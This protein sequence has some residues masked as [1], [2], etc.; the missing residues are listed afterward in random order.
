[1]KKR[2]EELQAKARAESGFSLRNFVMMSPLHWQ[3]FFL[4]LLYSLAVTVLAF[5]VCYPVAFAIAQPQPGQPTALLFLLLLVPYAIN[6]LLRIF[7]WTMIL[8]NEG[9]LNRVL[10]SFGIIDLSLGQ[11]IRWVASNGTVFVVMAYTYILFMVFP[12][13]NTIETLDRSQ[14]EAAR[15]LARP[16]GASTPESC[17]PMP[18]PASRSA[19]S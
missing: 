5:I 6:E 3:V 14:I 13:Y 18:S 10:D 7:A 17:C 9:I 8:A 16:P 15:D 11:S 2:A 19:R 1:M 4:T 12:I